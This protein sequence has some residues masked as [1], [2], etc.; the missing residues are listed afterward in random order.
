VLHRGR[1]G[2][3]LRGGAGD[4]HEGGVRAV[5]AFC[6]GTSPGERLT[7][8][9]GAAGGRGF[10]SG[11]GRRVCGPPGGEPGLARGRR[12]LHRGLERPR[13]RARGLTSARR[14]AQGGWRKRG[15]R[16]SGVHACPSGLPRAVASR[17]GLPHE[18][19]R[20]PRTIRSALPAA[21][22]SPSGPASGARLW[23]LAARPRAPARAEPDAIL[24]ELERW[25]GLGSPPTPRSSSSR[26]PRS[27][28]RASTDG[29]SR[30]PRPGGR[31]R[32]SAAMGAGCSTTSS[33]TRSRIS[34]STS[35]RCT[36][37]PPARMLRTR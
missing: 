21:P 26:A 7:G 27:P 25:R 37:A 4:E 31:R 1:R 17:L 22:P 6:M 8:R 19:G 20:G 24:G 10:G 23:A 32:R 3:L 15:R 16:S 36:P 12:A 29:T 2:F 5:S 34:T 11:A 35:K 18:L 9:R 30:A 33:S 13:P 28:I 14:G